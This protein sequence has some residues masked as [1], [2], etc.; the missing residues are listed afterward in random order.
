MK[1]EWITCRLIPSA[2]L[3]AGLPKLWQQVWPFNAS[4][5]ESQDR[6]HLVYRVG[7]HWGSR[8]AWCVLDKNFQTIISAPKFLPKI[9]SDVV[10]YEDPRCCLT[11]R[12]MVLMQTLYVGSKDHFRVEQAIA[13]W[14]EGHLEQPERLWYP[15]ST[16][17]EKN[18][19]LFDWEGE[20]FVSYALWQ[21]EHVVLGRN[22]R[23]KEWEKYFVTPIAFQLPSE[24][25]QLR[26]GTPFVSYDGL[27][28]TFP[29]VRHLQRFRDSYLLR[30][31]LW[32]V[33]IEP[34]PPFRVR[35]ITTGPIYVPQP[36]LKNDKW[37]L[38][39]VFPLGATMREGRWILSAGLQDRAVCLLE[40]D[41]EELLRRM[42]I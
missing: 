39:V 42:R 28:W 3:V 24:A 17:V 26:G 40:F 8:I 4:F 10:S 35:G 22:P 27:W 13:Y 41:H 38:Q 29:H 5:F 9:W 34:K 15:Q 23:R 16:Q 19:I 25:L 33:A 37:M 21:G 14:Q 30:Y 31:T 2:P 1:E 7:P 11:A 20:Y 12:E 36:I 18:W 6:I 32:A